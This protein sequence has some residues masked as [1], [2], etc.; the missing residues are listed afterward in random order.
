MKLGVV[1]TM[2]DESDV[3][4]QS[5]KNLKNTYNNVT[6]VVVHSDNNGNNNSIHEIIIRADQY[7]KLE[8][9]SSG[10]NQYT[11]ASKAMTRNYSTGFVALK[12]SGKFDI[13]M[14][15]TGDTLIN[16]PYNLQK[17]Y[18]TVINNKQLGGYVLRAIGQNFHSHDSDPENGKEGGRPQTYDNCDIMPQFFIFDGKLLDNNLFCDIK[19]TNKYTSEQCLGDNIL[20]IMNKLG[21]KKFTDHITILNKPHNYAYGFNDGILLQTKGLGHTRKNL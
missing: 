17:Y 19:I 11:I 20:E 5:I 8:D 12:K 14:G 9:L 3:V 21:N 10:S 18:N 6:I 13:V 15:I 16:T 2:Y 1:I 7:F 4:L